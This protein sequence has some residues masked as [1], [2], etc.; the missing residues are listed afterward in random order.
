[1]VSH[2]SC[3]QDDMSSQPPPSQN[4]LLF[5][6]SSSDSQ[7]DQSCGSICSFPS[8]GES[9]KFE[10][11]PDWHERIVREF[12]SIGIDAPRDISYLGAGCFNAVYRL[13]WAKIPS[14]RLPYLDGVIRINY[15]VAIKFKK[16]RGNTK[17]EFAE[18]ASNRHR[19]EVSITLYLG[20][21]NQ[22]PKVYWDNSTFE[23]SFGCPYSLM[24]YLPGSNADNFSSLSAAEKLQAVDLTEQAFQDLSQI[25]F[26][27]AGDFQATDEMPVCGWLPA[28]ESNKAKQMFTIIPFY[29]FNSPGPSAHPL[30]LPAQ[31]KNMVQEWWD[32]AHGE[33]FF[34]HYKPILLGFDSMQSQVE[35]IYDLEVRLGDKLGNQLH[36]DDIAPRNTMFIRHGEVGASVKKVRIIDHDMSTSLPEWAGWMDRRAAL[37]HLR[38]S[39]DLLN[40]FD[41]ETS[42]E[43]RYERYRRYLHDLKLKSSKTLDYDPEEAMLSVILE[44]FMGLMRRIPLSAEQYQRYLEFIEVWRVEMTTIIKY[45]EGKLNTKS[46]NAKLSRE[47]PMVPLSPPIPS[48]TWLPLD[49]FSGLT[50]ALSQDN[51][52]MSS[53][54]SR[55]PPAY[56]TTSA[57]DKLYRKS[58]IFGGFKKM[59]IKMTTGSSSSEG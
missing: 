57:Y 42:A 17:L 23:N 10:D 40:P 37:E 14:G 2:S 32:Y 6:S 56:E 31:T 47:T 53:S 59:S 34:E 46:L 22:A 44:D 11:T 25:P 49:Y 24:E 36:H 38:K 48:V 15:P 28:F 35:E 5:R 52:H 43:K 33:P 51:E 13:S 8:F 29:A 16:L 55:E 30:P 41:S 9:P 26:E 1:M 3:T 54:Q 20:T 12:L 7:S 39:Q 19:N 58:E 21:Q 50:Y 18:W 27:A 45:L 4:N